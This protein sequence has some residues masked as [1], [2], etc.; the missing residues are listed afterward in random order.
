[1]N[2]SFWY[3][4]LIDAVLPKGTAAMVAS[5][6]GYISMWVWLPLS[7]LMVSLL[8]LPLVPDH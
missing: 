8:C 1:M 5:V 4:A 3:N 6:N 7:Y 2:P